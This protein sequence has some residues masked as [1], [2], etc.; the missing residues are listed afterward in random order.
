MSRAG[1]FGSGMV[2]KYDAGNK[3][4]TIFWSCDNFGNWRPLGGKS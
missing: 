1:T 2:V 3:L 4:I